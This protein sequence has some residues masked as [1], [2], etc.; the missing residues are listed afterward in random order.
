MQESQKPGAAASP[1][2][3][4]FLAGDGEMAQLMRDLDWSR[5]P[6]G[7]VD[8]WPQ[9]LRTAVSL[10]LASR[11]PI[12]IWWGPEYARFYND[13]YRPILGA[14]K[15]PQFLGRPGRDCWSEI[16]DVIGPM[17]DGVRATG[18]ATWSEDFQLIL[19]RNGYQEETYFTFSYAP[20]LVEDGTVGG[21]FCACA[22]TT[23]RVLSERRLR[24][25]RALGA[26]SAAAAMVSP[27][28]TIAR[29]V[30][31]LVES[32]ADVPFALAY[33]IEP[34]GAAA[35]LAAAE[36]LAPG[37]PAS[38]ERI[39]LAD[40]GGVWPLA[41]VART[42]ACRRVDTPAERF[43][44]LPGGAWP[45]PC[46]EAV[47]L[48]LSRSG[49][50]ALQGFLVVGVS[51]RR[52]LDAAYSDFF[53]LAAGHIA[54][55]IS[56][57]RAYQEERLRAE[58]RAE[59][60]AR[61]Q[62][63]LA[64]AERHRSRLETLFMQAPAGIC[65][66]RGPEHVFELANPRYLELVGDRDI[67]GKRLRDALP[68]TAPAVVPVLDRVYQT[69]EPFFGNEFA[70]MLARGGEPEERFFNFIY[71]PI[72]DAMARVEGIAVLAFEVTDQVRA[73]RRAEQ[74]AHALAITNQDLDQFAYVAS[75][76]LKAP[77]RGIASLSEWIEEGLADKMN[78]EARQQMR[79]LRGRVHRL[80]ALIE[81]I[82]SY[83]R[84]GRIR[85][86]LSPVDVGAVVAECV[87]LLAPPPET[88]IAVGDGMPT[89]LAER[90]PVQQVFM[91]LIGNALK[92]ARRADAVVEIACADAGEFYDFTVKDN[93]PGIPPQFQE[94][95][96]GI[97]QTLE[98]R[99]KVEGTG[100]GLSV[101]K[102]IVETR[103]GRVALES[104]P[105]AGATFHVFW[106]K[107][108]KAAS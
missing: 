84:A 61:E 41:D 23:G 10:C 60:L 47:V 48:P 70:A 90:V 95:I 80:E 49:H 94:R 102:K 86:R 24:A 99:D 39:P 44:E 1:G 5:T 64:E 73:R 81:G 9:S 65:V 7:P 19:S 59:L 104:E 12:E 57:A 8:R 63:A 50:A 36:G 53:E 13:A 107:R 43:G 101:V 52:A 71:Q 18:Q 33:M 20:V 72:Y 6:V 30:S 31:T 58:E 54:T 56:G 105:Y 98:A 92:H 28:E 22:E 89:I 40:G 97:F 16:W 37:G 62:A 69:G 77:L 68:E 17:L 32:S 4:P 29:S 25:L 66:L 27:E 26:Q 34:G 38:P 74:L 82:L 2:A 91:H 88:R 3:A 15:H 42:R 76:D 46:R 93:G 78:D 55:T 11:H 79:M 83:S 108:P 96:W 21:I 75:H 14:T 106:P 45:E 100:I 51:P 35:R 67:L 103:G 87:E 85:D